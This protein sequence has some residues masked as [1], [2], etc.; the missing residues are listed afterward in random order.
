MLH[1]AQAQQVLVERRVVTVLGPLRHPYLQP[2]KRL[3][4]LVIIPVGALVVLLIQTAQQG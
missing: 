3:V 1:Q 4:A 2:D